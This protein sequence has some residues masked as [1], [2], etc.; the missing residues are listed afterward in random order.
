M[1]T[2]PFDWRRSSISVWWQHV[3]DE[4]PFPLNYE[5]TRL[6]SCW[7]KCAMTPRSTTWS[8]SPN[9]RR[10]KRRKRAATE[11]KKKRLIRKTEF[12]SVNNNH[13]IRDKSIELIHT[14]SEFLFSQNINWLFNLIK[15]CVNIFQLTNKVKIKYIKLKY[16]IKN[17][18][19]A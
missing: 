17:D 6:I 14:N 10:A 13:S 4:T 8:K 5:P 15:E 3:F 2:C 18:V 9:R 19:L 7:S 11:T 1:S 16:W 12:R